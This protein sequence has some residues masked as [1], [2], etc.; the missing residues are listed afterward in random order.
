MTFCMGYRVTPGHQPRIKKCTHMR[1]KSLRAGS[2]VFDLLMLF[3]CVIL[4]TMWS[5]KNLQLLCILLFAMLCLSA[6]SMMFVK[7]MLAVCI[8]VGIVV[9]AKTETC[10]SWIVSSQLSCSWWMSVGF[11]VVCSP[12]VCWL[13]WWWASGLMI[14]CV[15][16]STMSDCIMG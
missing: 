3:L 2:Q 4:H 13:W 16:L 11:V 9:W 12:V 10:L 6:I 15:E 7:I 5:G 14:V 8:L 1:V